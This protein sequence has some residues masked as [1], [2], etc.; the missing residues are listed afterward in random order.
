MVTL[1]RKEG[2]NEDAT[3]PADFRGTHYYSYDPVDL[4]AS[5]SMLRDELLQWASENKVNGV[6]RLYA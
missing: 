3:M 4:E 6:K 5:K 1:K 2:K